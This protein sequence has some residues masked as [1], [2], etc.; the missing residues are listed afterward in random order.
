MKTTL[1]AT[2]VL[3]TSA[4][5]AG[6]A[7]AQ[8]IK[9]GLWEIRTTQGEPGSG[10]ALA[11]QMAKMRKDIAAMP[12]AQRKQM[13]AA[14]AANDANEVRF[15]DDG[16]TLKH[17]VSKEEA[18]DMGKMVIKDANCTTQRTPMAGGEEDWQPMPTSAIF[19]APPAIASP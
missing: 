14:L 7:L 18:A 1:I 9:P 10:K 4:F 3:T 15:T 6:D 8:S 2:A 16:M 11:A 13:E 17:C 5:A 12:A 19:S